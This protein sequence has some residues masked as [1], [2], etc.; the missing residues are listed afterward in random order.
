MIEGEQ[1]TFGNSVY[2][3]KK[4]YQLSAKYMKK[5]DLYHKTRVTLIKISGDGIEKMDFA[6]PKKVK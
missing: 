3:V 2:L 5:H 4:V 6:L 1:V